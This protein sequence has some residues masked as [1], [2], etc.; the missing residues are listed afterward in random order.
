[1]AGTV[2]EFVNRPDIVTMELRAPE[3]HCEVDL[4]A[5]D[6][7]SYLRAA[8]MQH[9]TTE[10]AVVPEV[11]P[12]TDPDTLPVPSQDPEPED[13]PGIEPAPDTDPVPNQCP[14]W[15]KIPGPCPDE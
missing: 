8:R 2:L 13:V 15:P 12:Q 9:A 7:G 3:G 5:G 6:L 11:E 1:M 14:I 4:L 10:P